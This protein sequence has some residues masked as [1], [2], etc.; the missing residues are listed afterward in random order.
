MKRT[1]VRPSPKEAEPLGIVIRPGEV[2]PPHGYWA[3]LWTN[4]DEDAEKRWH[5]LV[6]VARGA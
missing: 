3:Y 2:N 1:P 5:D 4:D 6:P